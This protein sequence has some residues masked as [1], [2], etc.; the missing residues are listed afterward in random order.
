MLKLLWTHCRDIR[1]EVFANKI[2]YN[3]P[4]YSENI[5][6]AFNYKVEL[7]ETL[8]GLRLTI[9]KPTESLGK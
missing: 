6:K 2:V 3:I 7:N 5:F 9:T 8:S 4:I 1:V